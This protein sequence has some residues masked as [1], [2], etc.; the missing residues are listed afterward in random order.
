M[1]LD[2][3][4]RYRIQE[5]MVRMLRL[6]TRNR[7]IKYVSILF[8]PCA[9]A[10]PDRCFLYSNDTWQMY[11]AREIDKRGELDE[12]PF[13]EQ[14]EQQPD[15]GSHD[16]KDVDMKDAVKEDPKEEDEKKDDPVQED[17]VKQEEGVKQENGTKEDNDPKQV[18][19]EEQEQQ[20]QQQPVKERRPI[21]YFDMPLELRVHLL[22][23]L[24]EVSRASSLF[25]KL[26]YSY[27]IYISCSGNWMML[28]VSGN[29]LIA[30]K[31]LYIG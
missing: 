9:N 30:K 17:G 1:I 18:A 23:T 26:P 16:N 4:E 14:V 22:H 10:N 7:F 21:N 6:L 29:I 13:Y 3:A 25:I 20:Q 5:L 24:C 31:M 27:H 2:P 8:D 15:D 19:D 28:S 11:F 12:N